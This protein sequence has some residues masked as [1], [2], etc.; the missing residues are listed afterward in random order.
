[1]V[2]Q[3]RKRG[4]KYPGISIREVLIEIIFILFGIFFFHLRKNIIYILL[5]EHSKIFLHR[6]NLNLWIE[7]FL[8]ST[9]GD[10]FLGQLY[11]GVEFLFIFSEVVF[12]HGFNESYY[13]WTCL[14]CNIN[15]AI[16]TRL[17]KYEGFCIYFTLYVCSMDVK[18]VKKANN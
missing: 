17:S 10:S 15:T 4:E 16:S 8:P 5:S 7:N 12:T 2:F 11:K 18:S 6:M 13:Y 3:I 1:M 9:I 14:S